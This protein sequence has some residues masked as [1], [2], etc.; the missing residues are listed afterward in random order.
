MR[1]PVDTA[2]VKFTFW[3]PASMSAAPVGPAPVTTWSRSSGMPVAFHTSFA[4]SRQSGVT[5]EGFTT[6][7]LPAASAVRASRSATW[8]GVFHGAITPTTPRGR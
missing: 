8:K 6:T 7:A 1:R 3:M 4:A 2:P 5:S